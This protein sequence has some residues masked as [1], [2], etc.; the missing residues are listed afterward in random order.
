MMKVWN[1][2]LVFTTFW[3]TI[4][5][6]F[7]TRSGVI[8]SVHAFAQ[9]DIGQWFIGFLILILAV[10]TIAYLKNR[11]YLKSDNKLDSVVSRESSFLFNNL[12]LLVAC[13]AVFSGTVFPVVSEWATGRK[14]AW[15]RHSLIASTSRLG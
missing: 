15:A 2:W 5:G 10:C 14:S 4:F 12:I 11:D 6:T 1:V 13:V 3:L 8:S 7:L 9:S